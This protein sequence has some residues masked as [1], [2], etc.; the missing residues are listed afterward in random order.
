MKQAAWVPLPGPLVCSPGA[1][2]QSRSGRILVAL[3]VAASQR[4]RVSYVRLVLMFD[5]V[6]PVRHVSVGVGV[7][8]FDVE[9]VADPLEGLDPA[10]LARLG[11]ELASNPADPDPQ[12]VQVVAVFGPPDLR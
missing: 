1:V 8:G 7:G 10:R 12:V 6:E 5:S 3:V 9:Q 2:A 11:P 4:M